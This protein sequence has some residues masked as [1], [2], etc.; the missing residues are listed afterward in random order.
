MLV[1][2]DG[3]TSFMI[4]IFYCYQIMPD[5]LSTCHTDKNIKIEVLSELLT[6]EEAALQ[7]CISRNPDTNSFIFFSYL[8]LFA[9]HIIAT[10]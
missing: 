5:F 4:Y 10:F 6:L 1:C 8:V 2:H 7:N 9:R 3:C